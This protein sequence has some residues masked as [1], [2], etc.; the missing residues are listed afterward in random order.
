MCG[1]VRV[2]EGMLVWSWQLA[3]LQWEIINPYPA[4]GKG[5]EWDSFQGFLSLQGPQSVHS[6]TLP[7]SFGQSRLVNVWKHAGWPSEHSSWESRDASGPN[8]SENWLLQILA[9]DIFCSL[10][11]LLPGPAYSRGVKYHTSWPSRVRTDARLMR[12]GPGWGGVVCVGKLECIKV[13]PLW[14]PLLPYF[15]QLFLISPPSYSSL[16]F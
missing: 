4:V 15:P 5:E 10:S 16:Q 11:S 13:L 9:K 6:A 2:T 8:S 7:A 1:V 14:I 12:M 3:G